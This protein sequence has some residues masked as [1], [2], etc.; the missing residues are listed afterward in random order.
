MTILMCIYTSYDAFRMHV[1]KNKL[2]VS[3]RVTYLTH[4][5]RMQYS[6]SMYNE[7]VIDL[8]YYVSFK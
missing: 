8:V 2:E 6:Q 5:R 4:S 7:L 1:C 3:M